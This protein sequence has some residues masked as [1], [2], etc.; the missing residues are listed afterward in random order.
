MKAVIRVGRSPWPDFR[1]RRLL[2]VA[3][4]VALAH[5]RAPLVRM[6]N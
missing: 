3:R 6:D 4:R 5:L 2:L 1:L